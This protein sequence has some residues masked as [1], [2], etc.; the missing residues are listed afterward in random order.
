[1]SKAAIQYNTKP[2]EDKTVPK[3]AWERFALYDENFE[4]IPK[5]A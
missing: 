5:C 3:S 4:F 2:D 1:M